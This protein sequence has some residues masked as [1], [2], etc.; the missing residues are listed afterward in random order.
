MS[1]ID[2]RVADDGGSLVHNLRTVV[3]DPQGRVF[4]QFDGNKWKAEELADA[5][6]EASR[7]TGPP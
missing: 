2:F 6:A 4:R 3:L 7:L 1:R 5:M